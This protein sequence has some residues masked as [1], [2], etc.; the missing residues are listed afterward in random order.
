[1]KENREIY[2]GEEELAPG[3]QSNFSPGFNSEML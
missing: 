3:V 2:K 1:M